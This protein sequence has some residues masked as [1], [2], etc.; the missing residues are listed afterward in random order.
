MSSV[1][2]YAP[3]PISN[4]KAALPVALLRVAPALDGSDGT[5]RA[6][7]VSSTLAA[8]N[9]VAAVTSWFMR[10]EDVP[11]TFEAYKRESLRLVLWA[12][13]ERK[14]PMS[15]LTH[16]DFMAYEKFLKNPQPAELWIS[17]TKYPLD[18]ERWRAFSGPLSISS[19]RYALG[20]INNLF[21]WLV[22]AEYL[23]ANPLALRKD[24]RSA[25]RKSHQLTRYLDIDQWI[26]TLRYI[27]TMPRETERDIDH[28]ERSRWV[29]RLF[30]LA[31]MRI[32]EVCT[33]LMGGLQRL[34]DPQGIVRWHLVV[35]GKGSKERAIPASDELVE[36]MMRYRRHIGLEPLPTPGET[37]P[38]VVS[39]RN[40]KS[41]E[42]VK[43]Q[44]MDKIVKAV[45][46]GTVAWLEQSDSEEDRNSAMIIHHA[47]AHWI[48]HTAGS[49]MADADIDLRYIRDVM[50]HADISTTN[51]YLHSNQRARHDEV[52]SRHRLPKTDTE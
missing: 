1:T 16:E 38:L 22:N 8:N 21:T 18:D 26:A 3:P 35:V 39:I 14:K 37:T 12:H 15:S 47:S 43:R 13:R 9:D 45:F 36:A 34:R 27:E 48:R 7:V 33:N 30:Y 4:P 41:L 52:T 11:R 51:Q 29:F 46:T 32:S 40:K 42:P 31:A 19:V 28:Y 20:V 23:R 50:G 25:A 5:N 24:D 49:H 2:L 44:A 17:K 10:Y 6:V